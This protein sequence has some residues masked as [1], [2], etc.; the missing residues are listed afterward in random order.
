MA[1]RINHTF[2][3]KGQD[4]YKLLAEYKAGAANR[5]V[6]RKGKMKVVQAAP[7]LAETFGTT[8]RDPI[9]TVKDRN[10]NTVI[11]ATSGHHDFEV[12]TATGGTL[13][14]GGRCRCCLED[15][16]GV[17]IGYP[18]AYQEHRVLTNTTGIAQYKNLYTFWVE[19]R[20]CCFECALY[21]LRVIS[22][23]PNDCR[24]P[25]TQS[26]E[27]WLNMLYRLM[28]PGSPPLRQ[29][30]D[31]KLLQSNGSHLTRAQWLDR[32]HTYRVTDRILM[33]PAKREYVQ[34]AVNRPILAIAQPQDYSLMNALSST[35]LVPSI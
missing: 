29:S 5:P 15:F 31:P 26:S 30:A 17:A 28:Y 34:Q 1:T 9:F 19:D 22:A 32:R 4:P 16:T 35:M 18:V 12:F 10:N 8:N 3:I 14:Q 11:I 7:M 25:T 6:V 23:R 33:I 21:Y 2:L 24:D 20:F 27:Q 13:A